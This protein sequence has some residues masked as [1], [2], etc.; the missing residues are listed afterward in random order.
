MEHIKHNRWLIFLTFFIALILE[1]L[2]LPSWSIWLRPTWTLLVLIYWTLTSPETVGIGSA[3][4]VGILLDLLTGT[5]LG[6]HAFVMVIIA[7]IAIKLHRLIRAFTLLQQTLVVSLL[8]LIYQLLIFATQGF[9]A[10]L[11][12]SPL[13]WLTVIISTLLW[14][15]IFA[16]LNRN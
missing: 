6:E 9:L 16:L 14:P 11:P 5:L 12:Y 3:F 4:I 10:Q 13:Y 8:I 7:Y 2:P 1:I 15:W